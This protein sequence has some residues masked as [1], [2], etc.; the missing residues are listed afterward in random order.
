MSSRFPP[1]DHSDLNHTLYRYGLSLAVLFD[2]LVE[3]GVVTREEIQQRARA[4]NL[5]LLLHDDHPPEE[6]WMPNS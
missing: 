6:P 1:T 5:E 2:L 4:L 3:K